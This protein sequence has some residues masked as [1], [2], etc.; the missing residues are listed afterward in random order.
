MDIRYVQP[1]SHPYIFHHSTTIFLK[2]RFNVPK[3]PL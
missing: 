2:R 3:A 1:L